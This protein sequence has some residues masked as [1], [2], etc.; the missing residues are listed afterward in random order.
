[1]FLY[2]LGAGFGADAQPVN[3]RWGRNGAVG[4]HSY[5]KSS[6]M[7]GF[8]QFFIEL[9]QGFAAGK[10]HVRG[11]ACSCPAV[12]DAPGQLLGAGEFAP[13]RSCADK[14]GITELACRLCPVGFAAAPQIAAGKTAKHGSPSAMYAFAL[15]GMKDFLDGV[16]HDRY[17]FAA[18]RK[19]TAPS[20]G[21]SSRSIRH[22]SGTDSA[23]SRAIHRAIPA[24]SVASMAGR[25]SS[26]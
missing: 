4:F 8:D 9:Q 14:I 24:Q 19:S 25:R 26:G 2:P 11:A 12:R 21:F 13:V 10:D 1:M 6:G 20:S 3:S 16:G 7:H 5:F 18:G 17:P 15:Q 23:N 22:S